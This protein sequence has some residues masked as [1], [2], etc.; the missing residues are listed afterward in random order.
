MASKPE[1]L[2]WDFSTKVQ[3]QPLPEKYTTP[4]DG[5]RPAT[6]AAKVLAAKGVIFVCSNKV[7]C[8]IEVLVHKSFLAER[9]FEINSDGLAVL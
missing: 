1:A 8:T 3:P 4:K 7:Q 9:Y 2:H 5:D 6:L